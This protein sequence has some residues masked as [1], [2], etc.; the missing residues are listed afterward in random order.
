MIKTIRVFISMIKLSYWLRNKPGLMK[1]TKD[2]FK[3]VET[4]HA[5]QCPMVSEI[6][7]INCKDGTKIGDFVSLWAGIGESNPIERVKHLRAQNMA[8]K[9]MLHLAIT[10]EL[11]EARKKELKMTMDLFE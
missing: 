9:K 8:L 7:L 5:N 3:F 11:T 6:A 4:T 1:I 10:E 2:I